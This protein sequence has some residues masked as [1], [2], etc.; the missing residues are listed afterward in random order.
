M[1]RTY[2]YPKRRRTIAVRGNQTRRLQF[3]RAGWTEHQIMRQRRPFP[4]LP[5]I[6]L[7]LCAP[8]CLGNLI[9]NG[10]FEQ[11]EVDGTWAIFDAIPGWTL[12]AGPSIEI[13]RGVG[14]WTAFEGEQWLELDSD[15]N[16]GAWFEGE[17]GS[18]TIA[19]DVGTVAGERYRLGFAFSARPGVADNRLLIEFDGE[20]VFDAT[21]SGL[22]LNDTAWEYF[23][24]VVTARSDLTSLRLS[25]LS[26]SD[27]LG[28]LVDAVTLTALPGPAA[29][30]IIPVYALLAGPR[31]RRRWTLV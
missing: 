14:G 12:E 4:V 3:N 10:G 16:G 7:L 8:N 30:G 1:F 28:T 31:R 2:K 24:L 20:V 27:T 6:M 23:E 19:Q 21:A 15:E 26:A 11:S 9:I 25:D 29:M 17:L 18:S 22:G 5:G 13:Q